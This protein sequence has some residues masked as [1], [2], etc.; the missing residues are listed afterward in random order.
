MVRIE[1][2]VNIPGAMAG[3]SDGRLERG[4]EADVDPDTADHLAAIGYAERLDDG[5]GQEDL[6]DL[7]VD[8]LTARAK[9]LGLSGYSS[10]NKD[11]LVEAVREARG[12]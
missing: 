3:Q 11:A 5:A 10:L 4:E 8:E 2:R 6:D 1:A 9:E 12:P 7:T